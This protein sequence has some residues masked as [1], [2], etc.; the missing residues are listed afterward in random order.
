M[1]L[2]RGAAVRGLDNLT[3]GSRE[4]IAAHDV[5]LVE[6][7]IRDEEAVT[8]ALAGVDTVVHLAAYGSVVESVEDPFENFDVNVRGTLVLLRACAAGDVE[9]VVFASTGGAI[10]GNAPPPV[11]ET[12]LPWPI[13][14]YGASKLCGEAYCHAFAGSYALKTVALRFAN[15]YGPASDHKKGAV[16]TFIKRAFR[17]EPLVVYGDGSA[18]RDFLYVDDLCA[19]ICAAVDAPLEDE[20]VHLASGEETSIGE[21]AQLV[22]ELTDAKGTPIRYEERRRGEIERTFAKPER[23]GELL[24][25]APA[26]TLRDGLRKTV[27][28]FAARSDR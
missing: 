15:A 14:P 26:H 18:T 7:D 24:G 22:L 10:M 8:R 9:K 21:L 4:N 23:A 11:D 28:W 19:G 2:E 20:V 27:D 3:R 5:E 25:F 13:S 16:T 6:S 1:L 12:T 17:G